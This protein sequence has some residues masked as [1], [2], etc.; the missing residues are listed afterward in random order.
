MFH[1]ETDSK[2]NDYHEERGIKAMNKT[3]DKTKKAFKD[4]TG[5]S[6]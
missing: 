3:I 1:N 5:N 4:I 6:N 2:W